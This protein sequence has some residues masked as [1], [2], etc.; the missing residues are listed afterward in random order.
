MQTFLSTFR[1]SFLKKNSEVKKKKYKLV[2]THKTVKY[3]I[4]AINK[5]FEANVSMCVQ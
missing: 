4:C 3:I 5:Q 2:G 1:F